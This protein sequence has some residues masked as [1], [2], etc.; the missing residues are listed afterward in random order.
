[1]DRL[2]LK[3]ILYTKPTI[4][5]ALKYCKDK[6][7]CKNNKDILAKKI[8]SLA[9]YS[10]APKA[11]A[12]IIFSELFEV[13]KFFNKDPDLRLRITNENAERFKGKI[14]PVLRAFLLYNN[15]IVPYTKQELKTIFGTLVQ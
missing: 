1:M 5:D 8:L 14:S 10:L 4:K 6:K 11:N 7:I 13:T 2:I 9:G 12:V 15:I 3:L